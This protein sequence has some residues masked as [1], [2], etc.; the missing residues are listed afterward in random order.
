[1]YFTKMNRSLITPLFAL[2]MLLTQQSYAQHIYNV[3]PNFQMTHL[4]QVPWST[5]GAGDVVNIYYNGST[6]KEK[7][8]ISSS[9]AA[10]NPI[11][12]KGIAGPNGEKPIVDGDNAVS[13]GGQC[14][15]TEA[16]GLISIEPALVNGN[17]PFGSYS[18]YPTT[19]L[20]MV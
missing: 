13:T 14:Y 4:S 15:N 6:Y 9:G 1:M 20:L 2:L 10:G 7:F 3:G 8:L 12:I 11:T 18:P 19:L 17:C 5:L 16:Y